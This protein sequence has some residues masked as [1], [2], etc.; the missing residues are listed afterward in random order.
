MSKKRLTWQLWPGVDSFEGNSH[1]VTL[2]RI[3]GLLNSATEWKLTKRVKRFRY[4]RQLDSQESD[5]F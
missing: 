2:L 5:F 3:I 1:W 4:T